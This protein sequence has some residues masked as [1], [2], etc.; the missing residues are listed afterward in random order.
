M[1]FLQN[2]LHL[3]LLALFIIM[4]IYPIFQ[5]PSASGSSKKKE[6]TISEKKQAIKCSHCDKQ[7]QKKDNL[8]RHMRTHSKEPYNCD[9]CSF[10]TMSYRSSLAHKKKEHGSVH[11][12]SVCEF[13]THRYQNLRRHMTTHEKPHQCSECKFRASRPE[14][15]EKHVKKMHEKK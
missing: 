15:L 1:T 10:T 3:T 11:K 8:T 5:G 12:C 2:R 7:F 6:Q 13:T 4:F 14:N 9:H